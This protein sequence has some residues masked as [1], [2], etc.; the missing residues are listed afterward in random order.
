MRNYEI[1]KEI[2]KR[3]PSP[4]MFGFYSKEQ[5]FDR[6]MD[7]RDLIERERPEMSDGLWEEM[8]NEK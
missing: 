5:L 1:I 8:K 7:Y 6:I 2:H 4:D 3:L